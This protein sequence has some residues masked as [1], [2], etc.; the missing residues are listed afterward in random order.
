[1][2]GLLSED[3]LSIFAEAA[4][5]GTRYR[6]VEHR[7][8]EGFTVIRRTGRAKAKKPHRRYARR[9]LRNL[10]AT[11]AAGGLENA[12]TILATIASAHGV[13][14]GEVLGRS[15][16]HHIVV[17]RHAFFVALREQGWSLPRIGRLCEVHHTT[18]LAA[19]R[20]PPAPIRAPAVSADA[21]LATVAAR[22]GIRGSEILGRSRS[23]HVADARHEFFAT[24]RAQG[25][26]LPAIGRACRRDHATVL[27]SLRRRGPAPQIPRAQVQRR[28]AEDLVAEI[29]DRHG[30]APERILARDRYA[31]ALRARAELYAALMAQ[32]WSASAVA[33]FVGRDHTTILYTVK[34]RAA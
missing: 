12:E 1:M 3:V 10:R 14:M 17:A 21:A 30:L 32:G 28:A 26:S 22:H 29:S 2:K 33:K 7:F 8:G 23:A 6:S 34:R 18:V 31:P 27:G 5:Q 15:R 13:S 25:W 11:A 20:N 16:L 4:A 19:L 24:L 9:A